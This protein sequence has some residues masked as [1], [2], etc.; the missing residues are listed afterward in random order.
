[1][2]VIHLD[3]TYRKAHDVRA[4][5]EEI[6]ELKAKLAKAEQDIR[7]F[8]WYASNNIKLVDMLQAAK[9]NMEKAGLDTSWIDLKRRRY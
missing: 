2:K 7:N 1:M 5:E 9:R 3:I 6:K 4:L 8:Q